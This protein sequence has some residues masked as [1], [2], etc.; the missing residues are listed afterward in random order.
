MSSV[1]RYLARIGFDAHVGA[2]SVELLA[3]LQL[4]HL[5]H[6]P[7]ENLHPFHRRGVRTDVEWSYPKIVEQR[8]GGWCFEL[9][10]AFGALLRGL[11]FD[12]DYV[13]CQVWESDVTDW[14]PP[15]DH[16]GLLVRLGGQRWFVD[17]GF[18]DCC[19]Q[20]LL[21]EEGPRPA[22]PRAALVS[23]EAAAFVLTELA[24]PTADRPA[25]WEPQ[26]KVSLAPT[27]LAVFDRRSR[28]L[29][30]EPGL[31]WTEKPFATRAL[32][33]TG[34][35]VTLRMDV[36]RHRRGTGGFVDAAVAPAA[37]SDVL[38]DQFGIDDRNAR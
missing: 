24:A 16:L 12:T 13:S 2:P 23:V 21:V 33:A 22:V 38:R 31:S 27:Q 34:S 8:R 30:T 10:G 18:G 7:F 37:W 26:L 36:L 19:I 25:T 20:P 3:A 32:D 6:V 9:N 4:A 29:Q 17:V 1:E 5:V 11:G 35:R 28:Y 14:G 15:H